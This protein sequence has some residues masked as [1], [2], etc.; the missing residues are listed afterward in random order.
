MHGKDLSFAKRQEKRASP[1]DGRRYTV[2]P[3]FLPQSMLVPGTAQNSLI[4]HPLPSLFPSPPFL[5][6]SL[7]LARILAG[8]SELG[9]GVRARAIVHAVNKQ[10]AG[11][12][13]DILVAAGFCG[14]VGWGPIRFPWL[15]LG[16]FGIL[17]RGDELGKG[18]RARAIVHAVNKQR[19]GIIADI[20]VAAGFCGVVRWGPA[21]L[22]WLCFGYLGSAGRHSC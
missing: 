18:V 3:W 13:A 8:S 19:A 16:W 21:C 15:R 9:K 7:P 12:I 6:L 14:V 2:I 10:R 4:T 5:S 11:I 17:A 20:L 1:C 22:P